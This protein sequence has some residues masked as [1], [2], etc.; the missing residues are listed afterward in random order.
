MVAYN[1]LIACRVCDKIFSHA[2]PL[3]YHFEE[4]HE[5]EGYT[6]VIQ[7]NGKIY[8]IIIWYNDYF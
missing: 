1:N 3:L 5:R 7:R 4:V 2:L 6:L 8:I